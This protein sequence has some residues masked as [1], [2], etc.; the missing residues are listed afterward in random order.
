[1]IFFT[2]LLISM[3]ITIAV[4]PVFRTLA[5]KLHAMDIPD[6][7]KV[8]PRPMPKSGGIAMTIGALIPVLVWAPRGDLMRAILAGSG[9]V[10][11][12]GILDDFRNLGYKAKFAGQL[13]AA[14]LVVFYGGLKITNL[15]MLLPDDVCLPDWMA[16]P[17]TVVVIV[18]VTNAI[19]LADGLDGL[20]GGIS[21]LSFLCIGYLAYS[22]G[23]LPIAIISVAT[24]G[25]IF[26][27]LRFNTY[28]ASLFMGDGGSQLL[29]FLA[30]TLSLALT[31][32][33]TPLSP[34]LPLIILGFPVLDTLTVM[35]ERIR[36]GRSPFV[37]DKKHFHHKLMNLGLF[38]RD[39]VLAIYAIQAWLVTW[40]FV[41]RF[42]SEW[43]L[44]LS[45]L[46]FSGAVI[47]GFLVAEKTGWRFKRYDLV[48]SLIKGRL[49][50]LK[51][52]QVLIR[53]SFRI[54]EYGVPLLLLFT[55]AVPDHPPVVLSYLGFTL[56]LL[57][58]LTLV[59]REKWLGGSLRLALYLVIP[60]LVYLSEADM[61][62]WLV[63]RTEAIYNLSFG[64]LVFFVI[65]TLKYT[66]REKGFK[67]TPM[68]FLILF[69]ALVVPYLPDERIRS[70]HMGLIAAKIIVFFFSYEVLLGELRGE[71]RKVAVWTMSALAVAAAKGLV[72]AWL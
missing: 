17:L 48:D 62:P 56:I 42:H 71:F 46:L 50:A 47:T 53:F 16:I 41:F 36:E 67:T 58:L 6:P 39:A 26:G 59:F 31:Q 68:D 34:L 38:H 3:F 9:I 11:A 57:I 21:L 8:H 20:A 10:V 14:L 12:L 2:T 1:M 4:M 28:P 65:L 55:C 13:A 44:L 43:F 5:V 70:F 45:Y 49:R 19:N 54:V 32:R 63:G 33:N 22:T 40:A 66:R 60:L 23:Q 51:E 27:F 25:A 37:A 52:R 24:V 72:G 30:I 29:G 18:G 61:A 69:I 15:G 35:L 7:R 64:I